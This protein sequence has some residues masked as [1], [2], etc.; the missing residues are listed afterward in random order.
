MELY[1]LRWIYY[2]NSM[3]TSHNK[4]PKKNGGKYYSYGYTMDIIYHNWDIH[5]NKWIHIS[6]KINFNWYHNGQ[7]ALKEKKQSKTALFEKTK[8]IKRLFFE[9]TP[10][11]DTTTSED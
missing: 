11:S 1:V 2:T 5:E 7:R 10:G 3:D 9:E 4:S 6:I 8:H